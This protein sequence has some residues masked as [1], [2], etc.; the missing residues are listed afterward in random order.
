[1][2]NCVGTDAQSYCIETAKVM[3]QLQYRCC[4]A[5]ERA[6]MFGSFNLQFGPFH[7]EGGCVDAFIEQCQASQQAADE[8]IALGRTSY[9][10]AKAG[11]CL[12]TRREQVNECDASALYDPTDRT[13]D[14][15]FAGAVPD[16]DAC[17][18]DSEC[19]ETGSQCEQDPQVGDDGTVTIS[20]EGTC[21]GQG[22]EGEPCLPGGLCNGELRCVTDPTTY[23]QRCAPPG[24]EGAL[25]DVDGDCQSGLRC[26][27]DDTTYEMTCTAPGVVGD[28]CD[29]SQD[30]ADGLACLLDASSQY[31]CTVPG[32]AGVS[33]TTGADCQPGLLCWQDPDD[34]R[35]L[36]SA[37][38]ADGEQ[39][40]SS[41]AVCLPGLE[42]RYDD[43]S[44]D[45]FCVDGSNGDP[46]PSSSD[47]C[48]AG[49]IC[50]E[51]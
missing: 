18:A 37:P 30:C 46:C 7:D 47:R 2:L 40:G 14:D 11:E 50:R 27:Y 49:L 26:V 13:C 29:E 3:C 9:D 38:K 19:A 4:T 45:Y 24:G 44:G 17:T 10:G 31:L 42:C 8:S 51:N 22:D 16:G 41:A 1:M 23:E 39:C 20:L 48:Q 36:C 35:Y 6:T 15:I 34:Y 32:A 28:P 33:C 5:V 43:L 21:K 12:S 25:C